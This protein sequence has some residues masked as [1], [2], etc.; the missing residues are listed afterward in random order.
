MIKTINNSIFYSTNK[1]SRKIAWDSE[2]H[3]DLLSHKKYFNTKE[4]TKDG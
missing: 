2:S 3:F 1:I 4:A